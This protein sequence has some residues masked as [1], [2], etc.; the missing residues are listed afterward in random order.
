[1]WNRIV[2]FAH[3]R[4]FETGS[5]FFFFIICLFP[6]VTKAFARY[7]RLVDSAQRG[8]LRLS[9]PDFFTRGSV[10][11]CTHQAEILKLRATYIPLI[12]L[13][14][15][16]DGQVGRHMKGVVF[17]NN[18]NN[19]E[20]IQDH[21][22]YISGGVCVSGGFLFT[23]SVEGLGSTSGQTP[24]RRGVRAT[25]TI[26]ASFIPM[27][28]RAPFVFPS[29]P[30]DPDRSLLLHALSPALLPSLPST[31]RVLFV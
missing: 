24:A 5:E 17:K 23:A 12:P 3:W 25:N 1:M 16:P 14:L 19:T 27:F 29:P 8:E 28:R 30:D 15:L 13:F 4:V 7:I 6:W 2:C 31:D 26:G 22:R 10:Q 11:K 18:N 9:R 20:I 21:L